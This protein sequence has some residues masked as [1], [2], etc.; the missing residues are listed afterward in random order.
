MITMEPLTIGQ[1]ARRGGV[2]IETV[3]FY[4]RRGLLEQPARKASGYRQYS[5]EVVSRLHFI[6]RAKELGFS[7]REIGELIALQLNPKTTCTDVKQCAKA[8]INDIEGKIRD[9]Q[10]MKRALDKV[11]ASCKGYGP[12]HQCSILKAFTTKES[13]CQGNS[14]K[15]HY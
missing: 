15:T 1:L 9:L 3:R 14:R 2:G 7:L 12:A 5:P 13:C 4:E 8:K 6:R 10:R 11:V